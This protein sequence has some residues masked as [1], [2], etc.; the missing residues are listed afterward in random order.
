M[1]KSLESML[2]AVSK[3]ICLSIKAFIAAKILLTL[4][5][6]WVPEKFEKRIVALDSTSTHKEE[7]SSHDWDVFSQS[8]QLLQDSILQTI[9]VSEWPWKISVPAPSDLNNSLSLEFRVNDPDGNEVF[10]YYYC[11]VEYNA[12]WTEVPIWDLI[13]YAYITPRK[14][15]TY[16]LSAIQPLLMMDDIQP[17]KLASYYYHEPEI[18]DSLNIQ[19]DESINQDAQSEIIESLNI[20]DGEL[21]INQAIQWPVKI[22]LMNLTNNTSQEVV[23]NQDFKQWE[24]LNAFQYLD[25]SQLHWKNC[26]LII[27]E[28]SGTTIFEQKF[29]KL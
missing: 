17:A 11:P 26:C 2:K 1:N 15:G 27:Q 5:S 28:G 7:L 19:D 3:P 4:N 12:E 8:M 24:T 9:S 21:S 13:I 6:C 23:L 18:P 14:E 20:Q 22:I 25:M 29:Y 16:T 10:Y